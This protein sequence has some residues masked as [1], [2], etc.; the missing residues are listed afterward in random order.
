LVLDDTYL[1]YANQRQDAL[2]NQIKGRP[3]QTYTRPQRWIFGENSKVYNYDIFDPAQKLFGGL[4][5]IELDP[6][7]F[8]MKRRVFANR[9]QWLDTEKAWALESGWV[10]DFSGGT[11]EKYAPFKVTSLPELVEPPSYFNRE[12]I[13][14]FQMSWRDLRRY[15]YGLQSAGFDVSSL[16]VQWHKKIAYPLIAPISML[17]AI[18]FAILVGSRGAIG[19][20]ALGV[21]IGICYWA[22][23]ALLEAMGGIGQLP[24]MLAAWSPDLVFFFLGI[25]FFLKMPT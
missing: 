4:S 18:P 5:V 3:A 12:V 17:L 16:T 11:V 8:Q 19:G 1:P 2:R 13:Q 10:R 21:A 15:I 22:I 6:V 14:A 9:A 20:I 23:A 24:P 7:S 25:Y